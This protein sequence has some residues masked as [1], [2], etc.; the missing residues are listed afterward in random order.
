MTSASGN[1]MPPAV[2]FSKLRMVCSPVVQPS[3]DSG[4]P[5]VEPPRTARSPR[6]TFSRTSGDVGQSDVM[7]SASG[8][9]SGAVG[10]PL[11]WII[12]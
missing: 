1:V 11:A 3:V 5:Q 9:R 4:H 6:E 2:S 12:A 10:A 8:G 7:K